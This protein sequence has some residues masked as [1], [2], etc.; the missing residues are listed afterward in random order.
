MKPADYDAW[1]N[2]PRG[3]W[4][5]ETEF[6]LVSR[7][8]NARPEARL[9]DVGCGTGWFTRRFTQNGL[10]VTGLDSN[11]EWLAYAHSDPAKR[12]SVW[13]GGG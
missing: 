9:L 6:R 12:P 10:Q 2:T 13:L 1:Y 5:G 11:P 8:L 7:L 3:R 4:I